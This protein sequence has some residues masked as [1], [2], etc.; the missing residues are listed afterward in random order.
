[1]CQSMCQLCFLLCDPQQLQDKYCAHCLP[2]WMI[3][4]IA[5]SRSNEPYLYVYISIICALCNK[6]NNPLTP[7][8]P[9][10]FAAQVSDSWIFCQ[11]KPWL[12]N[13]QP[14][15]VLAQDVK[16]RWLLTRT[17]FFWPFEYTNNHFP[18]LFINKYWY[19]KN[20]LQMLSLKYLL[21]SLWIPLDLCD[22]LHTELSWR[23]K[24]T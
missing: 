23:H 9:S 17:T 18:L 21:T 13:W 19:F 11:T 15:L 16:K 10:L 22:I 24:Q 20:I 3:R 8:T 7:T 4:P 1:M 2:D 14:R 6:I 12:P 5:F